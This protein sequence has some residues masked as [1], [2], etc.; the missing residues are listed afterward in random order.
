MRS[1]GDVV[2]CLGRTSGRDEVLLVRSADVSRQTVQAS[3]ACPFRDCA[4]LSGGAESMTD[5]IAARLTDA[6]R[7]LRTIRT[8]DCGA[9]HKHDRWI[10][11][12]AL[13]WDGLDEH[14]PKAWMP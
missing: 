14:G 8:L 1:Y 6:V 5:Q 3:N 10:A 7:L 11:E 12:N 9:H 2:G 4:G 13:T